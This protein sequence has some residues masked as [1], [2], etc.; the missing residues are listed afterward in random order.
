MTA[1]VDTPDAVEEMADRCTAWHSREH[2]D[3][4]RHDAA[5]MLRRLHKRAVEAERERDA[6]QDATARHHLGL[7]ELVQVQVDTARAEGRA[8]ALKEAERERDEA[9]KSGFCDGYQDGE[10]DTRADAL[11]KIEAAILTLIKKEPRT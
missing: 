4:I 11:R 6:L 10:K 5:T 2:P 7:A 1:P 8:D 3:N 9:Y